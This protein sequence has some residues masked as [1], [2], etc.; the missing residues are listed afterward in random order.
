MVLEPTRE[1]DLQQPASAEPAPALPSKPVVSAPSSAGEPRSARETL[2]E[3]LVHCSQF[4]ASDV[5]VGADRAPYYRIHGQLAP[6]PNAP[7]LSAP[8]VAELGMILAQEAGRAPLSGPGSIDGAL[9]A[10]DGARFRF[11]VYRRSGGIAIALRRLEDVIKPLSQLGLPDSLY[12]LCDL[13]DGLVIVGGPTGSGKSTTLAT[14]IDRINQTRSGH[15]IT[16]EDPIEYVHDS[17][18]CLVDQRQV[19]TDAADFHEALVA[20]LR[21]DPDVVLVGEVRELGTIRTA[22]TAAE[23]GHL[24]FT[25]VHAGDCVGVIERLVSVFPA[26]EQPGVRRQL[27]LVLKAVICQHLLLADGKVAEREAR[28]EGRR[29][30]VV[31]SEVLR[32]TPAVANL[33][34]MGRSSQIYSAM[35]SG[36]QLGMQTLEQDLAKLLVQGEISDATALAYAR[37]P[38]IVQDRAARLR[39]QGSIPRV[40]RGGRS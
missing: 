6:L 31:T 7:I 29:R 37:N 35:E 25:T 11:N 12:E 15:V 2:A 22:I 16:I 39:G 3:L 19:G 24:V 36:Q 40:A 34:A 26:D 13:P 20:S 14:L 33:V 17:K 28:D 38:G 23:T 18:E 4:A 21:Q 9:R 32:V 1:N 30:R 5:H 27:A 10:P 8:L